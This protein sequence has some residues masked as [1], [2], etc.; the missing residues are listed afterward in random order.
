MNEIVKCSISG[1][2]FTFDTDAYTSLRTYMDALNSTYKETEDGEEIVTDIEARI[3]ELIL[4]HQN[5]TRVV[6][7]ALIDSIIDQMGSAEQIHETETTNPTQKEEPRIPRRLYRDAVHA[8]LGGVCAGLGNYFDIDPVWLRIGIFV[9]LLF[10]IIAETP[11]SFCCFGDFMINIFGVFIVS[12]IILWFAVPVARS[13]RQQ[14]E[15]KGERITT[16]SIR[17]TTR[18]PYDVD[19]RAKSIVASVISV[20]GQVVLI[21]LKILI[22]I[23]LFGLILAAIT[24]LIGIFA[25]ANYGSI[26]Y[27][28]WQ[29]PVGISILGIF[30]AMSLLIL[31]I[32]VLI[33]LLISRKPAAKV[34]LIICCIWLLA[35]LCFVGMGIREWH[36]SDRTQ[37]TIEDNLMNDAVETDDFDTETLNSMNDAVEAKDVDTKALVVNDSIAKPATAIKKQPTKSSKTN[38]SSFGKSVVQKADTTISRSGSK[39]VATKP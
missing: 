22:G 14:L 36:N 24:L 37:I 12:Y 21:L 1:I 5:N 6:N 10:Q 29:I 34:V 33:N 28:D 35:S 30:A 26:G 2:A 13:A 38:S 7:R 19:G 39:V 9:P 23:I 31:L 3:A 8:K 27:T 4:S 17:E 16:Q 11:L 32:Y 15:M 25:V 20:F 18:Q